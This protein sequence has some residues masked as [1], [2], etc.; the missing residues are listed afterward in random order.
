MIR[1]LG[2]IL[3]GLFTNYE[4]TASSDLA[5][6]TASMF[7]EL[8]AVKDTVATLQL[9]IQELQSSLSSC[10]DTKSSSSGACLYNLLI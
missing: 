8:M 1:C 2:V 4:V 5:A 6:L 10:E 9:E 7:E 3:L